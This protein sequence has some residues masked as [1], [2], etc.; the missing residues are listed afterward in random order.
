MSGHY[1]SI[2]FDYFEKTNGCIV[3]V[4]EDQLFKRMLSSTIFKIIGTKRDCLFAFEGIQS[5]LRKVQSLQKKS[6]DC[7]VFIER[8]VGGNT[9]T[10]TIVTLKRLM[11]DLKIIVLVGGNQAG[12]HRLF[13][14]NRR[15]QCHFQARFL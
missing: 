7:I 8:W 6:V 10:E 4:T 9:T 14:R 12:K 11:P 1:D 2:V 13:L 5:G 3:L 15:Q